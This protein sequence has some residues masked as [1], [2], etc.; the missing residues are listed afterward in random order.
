MRRCMLVLL[1]MVQQ[2]QPAVQRPGVQLTRPLAA[3][4][5]LERA[6]QCSCTCGGSQQLTPDAA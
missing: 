1:D 2:Q 6:A 3:D 5:L 4:Q